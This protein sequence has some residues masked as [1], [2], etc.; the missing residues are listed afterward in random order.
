MQFLFNT[1]EK[2]QA[3]AEGNGKYPDAPQRCPQKD[4]K[5]PLKMKKHGYYKRYVLITDF[6]GIIR[7]RRYK[8][9]VCWRTVSMLPSFCIPRLQY[10]A[11]LIILALLTA[12]EYSVKYVCAKWA[13]LVQSLT[14]RHII[15]YRKRI[16][17]N[18]S[19]IQLA[20]NL[21]SPGSIEL[22][23]ITG[24]SDWTR[25]FLKVATEIKPPRFNS[26]YHALTGESF[27]S[28]HSNV[29]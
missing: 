27:M 8:C 4:C 11:E 19:Y 28:L 2:P 18:R 22:K 20:L 13:G 6:S 1:E 21:M 14:R 24:D 17:R 5:V 15:F 9:S 3:Y 25:E 26:K 7:V 12:A 16:I 10:G 23:Q 29:A